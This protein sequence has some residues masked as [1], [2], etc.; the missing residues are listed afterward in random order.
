MIRPRADGRRQ[1]SVREGNPTAPAEIFAQ[2]DGELPSAQLKTELQAWI[3]IGV[4]RSSTLDARRPVPMRPY[5]SAVVAVLVVSVL[6]CFGDFVK[7]GNLLDPDLPY[8]QARAQ[9]KTDLVNRGAKPDG[10]PPIPPE[11]LFQLV[12]YQ[13]PVGILDAYLSVKPEGEEKYP[14][15]VWARGGHGGIS[16]WFWGKDSFLGSALTAPIVRTQGTLVQKSI[17]RSLRPYAGQA[18]G[19]RGG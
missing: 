17:S 4:Q 16:D 9:F 8:N 3:L 12:R 7:A 5:Q 15:L 10:P 1:A 2:Q 6:I 11:S 19:I 14:A 18:A 13:S